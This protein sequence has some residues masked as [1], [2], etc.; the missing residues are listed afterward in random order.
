MDKIRRIIIRARSNRRGKNR[1][2]AA[3]NQEL[4]LEDNTASFNEEFTEVIL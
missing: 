1:A 2:Y 3:I 4:S